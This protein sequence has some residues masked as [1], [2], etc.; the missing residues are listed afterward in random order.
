MLS[1]SML[2]LL[3]QEVAGSPWHW[4]VIAAWAVG[5][6]LAVVFV[7][8]IVASGG[9]PASTLLWVV[10]IL[11]LPSGLG[12]VLYYLF[13]RQIQL[14]RLRR[15]RTRQQR[16]RGELRVRDGEAFS[17]YSVGVDADLPLCRLL[18]GIASEGLSA[19]NRVRWL[20]S[21]QDF[22]A[23]ASLAI[24][25]ARTFVHLQIYI[26]RPDS[27]GK[28]LLRLLIA[29]CKRGVAVRLLFDSVGSFG[30][31]ANDLSELRDAGGK[32]EA[33]LPLFWKRRPFTVNLR[34]HRKLLVV[35]GTTAFTGG[36]NVGDEYSTDRFGTKRTW[37]DA[38][39]R[40]EGPAV[41]S[42][43]EVFA[44]DW[45]HATEEELTDAKWFPPCAT[46][47]PDTVGIVCSG[48]DRDLQPLWLA[49]LQAVGGA[50]ERI[51]LSSP[52]LVP[53][54]TLLVALKLAA[55]RGVQVRIY[56]N[57]SRSEA[58]G[59]YHAQRS[60]YEDLIRNGVEVFETE[61]NYN[62]AKLLVVDRRTVVVGS[63][64]MD[65][66]SA[67]LNFE[68]A[69]VLPDSPDFAR[70]VL[71]T[72]DERAGGSRRVASPA[73]NGGFWRLIDGLCRLLS[74]LL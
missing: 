61:T 42:M 48:P 65:M 70:D 12:L 60:Y 68:I 55:A 74:P 57:G 16:W 20:P 66:R 36:R 50:E 19:G 26:F 2:A 49:V 23:A 71:L 11:V 41:A 6:L 58:I 9:A 4:I 34:N 8:R 43:H 15:L 45:Y 37:L 29:A 27:T 17:G 54:P 53:P 47:G 25:S 39:V 63:A 7:W 59:L 31:G 5:E 69:A 3:L 51:D 14:R 21:G 35:D 24:E 32:A 72:L 73:Q 30:L 13:P 10:L 18:Q 44:E 64:N 33:F 40:I 38:M 22:F 46:V 56:T 62:H 67:H 52:Y 28:H 1:W